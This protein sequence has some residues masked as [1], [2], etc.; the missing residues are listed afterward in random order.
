MLICGHVLL[1][2]VLYDRNAPPLQSSLTKVSEGGNTEDGDDDDDN[3]DEEGK[4][5]P[6]EG[7]LRADPERLKAFNVGNSLDLLP[8]ISRYVTN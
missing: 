4:L 7:L 2:H 8:F 1:I 5:T 6:T 3:D